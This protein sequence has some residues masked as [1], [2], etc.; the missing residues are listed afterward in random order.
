LGSVHLPTA[1]PA[2]ADVNAPT[3]AAS[4]K[5]ADTDFTGASAHLAPTSRRPRRHE[6]CSGEPGVREVAKLPQ[7]L[8][9]TAVIQDDPVDLERIEFART[10]AVHGAAYPLDELAKRAS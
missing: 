7:L 6:S 10:E 3:G 4:S 1:S 5:L 9:S 8:G 2:D